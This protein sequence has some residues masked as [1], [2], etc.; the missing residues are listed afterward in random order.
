MNTVLAFLNDL[1]ANNHREWFESNRVRYE[2]SRNEVL[3]LTDRLIEEIRGFDPTIPPLNGKE[4]LF[5]IYR[6]VRFSPNK[7]PYKTY[8][9][10]YMAVGGR[11]SVR[12]GYYLHI[13]PTG[14]FMGGGIYMPESPV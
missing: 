8:F 6:D 9:G 3:Q 14:S 11:K 10:S 5:R 13:D 7:A 1:S 2:Q 12:A 4:C